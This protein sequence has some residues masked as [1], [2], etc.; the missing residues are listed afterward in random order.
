MRFNPR[1][2]HSSVGHT[3][4]SFYRAKEQENIEEMLNWFNSLEL[5]YKT[6]RNLVL[7]YLDHERTYLF[8]ELI[9]KWYKS[10]NKTIKEIIEESQVC[11]KCGSMT[12]KLR[13][14]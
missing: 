4:Q 6:Q 10:H 3:I 13:I 5:H 14:R 1:V 7:A 8:K 9:K 11:N 12:N 2:P